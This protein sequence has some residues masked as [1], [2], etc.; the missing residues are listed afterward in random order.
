MRKKDRLLKKREQ[1]RARRAKKL[2][3]LLKQLVN[4]SESFRRFYENQKS[5]KVSRKN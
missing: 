2:V 4:S 1:K 5:K 3:R